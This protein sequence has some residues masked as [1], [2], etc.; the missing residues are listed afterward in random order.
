MS[1][2][3]ETMKMMGMLF[4]RPYDGGKSEEREGG[5]RSKE[6]CHVLPFVYR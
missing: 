4:H 6:C 1:G 3:M 5:F 2:M